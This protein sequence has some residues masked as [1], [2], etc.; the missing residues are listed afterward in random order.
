MDTKKWY[1]SKINWVAVV[2]TAAQLV[3]VFGLIVPA[4]LVP[5]VAVGMAIAQSALTFV[6]RT[7]FTDVNVK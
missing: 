3:N 4:E 2:G 5:Q 7:W 6:M 1:E